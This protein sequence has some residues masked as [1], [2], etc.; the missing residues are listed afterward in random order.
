MSTVTVTVK[1]RPISHGV[2]SIVGG[3]QGHSFCNSV[4]CGKSFR[5]FM[6]MN[7]TGV[8]LARASRRQR[9]RHNCA[10]ESLVHDM[11]LLQ[12]RLVQIDGVA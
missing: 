3:R 2:G 12:L 11:L 1:A 9:G 4:R 8:F 7:K 5:L 10:Y 6:A